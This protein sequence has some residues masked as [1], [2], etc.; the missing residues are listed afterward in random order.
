[1]IESP[2]EATILRSSKF[3]IT[4][5]DGEEEPQTEAPTKTTETETDGP[6]GK[7]KTKTTETESPDLQAQLD[8]ERSARIQLQQERDAEVEA[9]EQAVREAGDD[10]E[11]VVAERDDYKK[12]YEKLKGLMETSYLDH[13]ISKNSKF[14][15]HDPE[16]VRTFLDRKAIRLDLD[17]GSVEGLDEQLRKVA[18]EK[19]YLV[20]KDEAGS[21]DDFTPP[22]GTTGNHP[23][24]GSARQRETDRNKLGTKYKIPGFSGF[25]SSKPM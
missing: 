1:M 16:A 18:R 7:N 3:R 8:S 15:F 2:S 13:A 21:S 12:K 4:C 6:E 25:A 22:P 10:N 5:G 11:R 17:T 19:P 23:R 9:R 20:R 14:D 24:G